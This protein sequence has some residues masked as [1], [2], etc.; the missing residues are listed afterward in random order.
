[1]ESPRSRRGWRARAHARSGNARTATRLPT[2]AAM[3]ARVP[4]MFVSAKHVANDATT[5]SAPASGNVQNVTRF[6]S[7][8]IPCMGARAP[9]CSSPARANANRA[10]RRQDNAIVARRTANASLRRNR[11]ANPRVA[12]I[13]QSRVRAENMRLPKRYERPGLEGRQGDH[14]RKGDEMAGALSQCA[15]ASARQ[16]FDVAEPRNVAVARA[17]RSARGI[18]RRIRREADRRRA[19]CLR[20]R[21]FDKDRRSASTAPR[22]SSESPFAG[23]CASGRPA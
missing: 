9:R 3:S 17:F 16:E 1:M 2:N 8:R 22:R 6:V 21:C 11:G 15:Q 14:R 13:Q 23:A 12:L 19:E 10:L 4:R 7:S 5:P 20:N 18:D